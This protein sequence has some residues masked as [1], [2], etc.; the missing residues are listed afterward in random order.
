M[1][2]ALSPSFSSHMSL[3][4]VVNFDGFF[5]MLAAQIGRHAK[6]GFVDLDML[7]R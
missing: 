1:V 5:V 4:D 3:N 7:R 6:L 2:G